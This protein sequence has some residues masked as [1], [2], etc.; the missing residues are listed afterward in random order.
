[1]CVCVC[2]CVCVTPSDD[3]NLIKVLFMVEKSTVHPVYCTAFYVYSKLLNM[4]SI[5]FL[6]YIQQFEMCTLE[7]FS[8]HTHT[9]SMMINTHTS[10]PACTYMIESHT[11]TQ[12]K[13]LKRQKLYAFPALRTHTAS[14]VELA[15]FYTCNMHSSVP[16]NHKNTLFVGTKLHASDL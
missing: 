14:T 11:H 12:K 3:K 10:K 4:Y 9:H 5:L 8:P 2:V 1:M 6:V 16:F 7:L 15:C 13:C